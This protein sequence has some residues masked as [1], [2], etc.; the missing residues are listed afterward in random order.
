[1][2]CIPM[3]LHIKLDR[4]LLMTVRVLKA[5]N[6]VR[7]LHVFLKQGRDLHAELQ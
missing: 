6:C 3:L 4:G 5:E 7:S 1:M 2:F